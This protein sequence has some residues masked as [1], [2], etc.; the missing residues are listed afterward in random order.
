MSHQSRPGKMRSH[1]LF[2]YCCYCDN[3][4][5]YC[6]MKTLTLEDYASTNI[7]NIDGMYF[8]SVVC[9]TVCID[10]M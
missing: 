6:I 9:V 1:D 8:S 5:N 2:N 3:S 10:V 7:P 4:L